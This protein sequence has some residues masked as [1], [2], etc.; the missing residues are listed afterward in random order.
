MLWPII[1][2]LIRR[3]SGQKTVRCE[4]RS[5]FFY[6]NFNGA[7][8]PLIV[9]DVSGSILVTSCGVLADS[10]SFNTVLLRP[11]VQSYVIE[12]CELNNLC[13]CHA[14]FVPKVAHFL[15]F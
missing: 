1:N 15:I 11:I 8:P 4:V 13:K 7:D 9:L 12:T 5:S 2:H 10:T 6:F 3:I 14:S